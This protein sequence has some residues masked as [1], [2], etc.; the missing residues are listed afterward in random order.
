M[1]PTRWIICPKPRPE[2]SSRLFCFPH[3]GVGPSAFRGWAER[4]KPDAEVCLVQLPGREGRLR[5]NLFSSIP[6]LV[7]PL[8]ENISAFLDRPFAFYGHS[9]GA[10]IAFETALR[11]RQTSNI[12]PVY[13]FVG[14]SPAPQLPWKHPPVRFLPDE[15]L[16]NEIQRRYG[17]MPPE[18]IC[19]AEMRALVL[20]ILRADISMV[21]TYECLPGP[22]L[23]CSITAFGGIE[24]QTVEQ[25][26]L[27]AW[28]HQTS[29]GFRLEML[30]G[31]HFFLQSAREPLLGSI[32]HELRVFG[33]S[34]QSGCNDRVSSGEF[35][36][37]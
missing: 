16:L 7:Q 18:V 28:T 14:A 11:L 9:L 30:P 37:P 5:D 29:A 17:V 10:T 34:N 24:D 31:N 26:S 8:A 22:R 25:S 23:D 20:R 1:I 35:Q 2:A 32:A 12:Q 33:R 36:V 15:D 3:A 21:E 27:E 4:L 13:L 19:D 6:E